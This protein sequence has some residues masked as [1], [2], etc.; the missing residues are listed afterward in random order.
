MSLELNGLDVSKDFHLD[1]NSR[2]NIITG[3]NGLGKSFILETAWWSLTQ[4]WTSFPILPSKESQKLNPTIKFSISSTEGRSESF[5]ADFDWKLQNWLIN[6][7]DKKTVPG[8]V[9]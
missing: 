1:F 2:L 7:K 3:D 6:K 4:S 8:L 9:I 5:R